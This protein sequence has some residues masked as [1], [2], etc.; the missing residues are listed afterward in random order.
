MARVVKNLQANA[1]DTGDKDSIPLIPGS[2]RSPGVRN[3]NQLQHSV[4]GNLMDR[5]AWQATF[6]GTSK[7]WT[8]L[9]N[10]RHTKDINSLQT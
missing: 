10:Q 9:S 5:E 8:Q 3:G 4:L 2:E 6:H 1:G 7:R